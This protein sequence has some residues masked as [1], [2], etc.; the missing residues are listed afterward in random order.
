M[1]TILSTNTGLASYIVEK[2]F[3]GANVHTNKLTV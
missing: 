2:K 3:I 1:H